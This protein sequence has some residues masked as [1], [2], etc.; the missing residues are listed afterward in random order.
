[1]PQKCGAGVRNSTAT[2]IPFDPLSPVKH[3]AALLFLLRFPDSP[4]PAFRRY[5]PHAAESAGRHAHSPPGF[6]TPREI[7]SPHGCGPGPAASSGEKCVGC[8]GFVA[9]SGFL[10]SVHNHRSGEGEASIAL[11]GRCSQSPCFFRRELVSPNPLAVECSKRL[12]H[13]AGRLLDQTAAALFFIIWGSFRLEPTH[14]H[15]AWGPHNEPY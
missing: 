1:M 3:N 10:H 6:R 15:C 12:R 7:S 13:H 5:Q 8:A 9:K 4:V 11:S 14:Y 2:R